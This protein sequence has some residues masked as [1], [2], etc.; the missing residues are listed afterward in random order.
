LNTTIFKELE[1]EGKME[2]KKWKILKVFSFCFCTFL[3]CCLMANIYDTFSKKLT[4]VIITIDENK[5]DEKDLPCF[6]L[7]PWDAYKK[8]GFH[9]QHEDFK[10]NTYDATDLVVNLSNIQKDFQIEEVKNVYLGR[11]FMFCYIKPIKKLD[12]IKVEISR[13]VNLKGRLHQNNY[14]IS[15][16][17]IDI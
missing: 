6:T 4:S 16:V 7:C 3:F 2:S 9:Y 1:K 10:I 17:F 15:C 13:N 14:Y 8:P 12:M 5:N 11:C